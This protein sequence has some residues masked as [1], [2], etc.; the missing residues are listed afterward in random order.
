MGNEQERELAVAEPLLREFHDAWHAAAALYATYP[1]EAIAEH[2]DTTAANC[3]RCHM[4]HEVMRRFDGCAGCV[5]KDIRGLKVLI[6]KDK[7]VWRFKKLDRLGRHSNY[8]TPQQDDFDDQRRLDGIPEHATR[9]TSGY[10]LD[11]TGLVMERIV[12]SRV[13]GRDILWIAQ[14]AIVDGGLEVRDI[15]PSRIA[16][17]ER[18]D[19][20]AAR[21]RGRRGRK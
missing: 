12:V 4:V 19:F 14:T 2:N 6:H 15:T 1:A 5:V 20:D 18:S 10:L 9:L 21:A 16:G 11:A 3:V 8:P 13:L 17:T 7:Q